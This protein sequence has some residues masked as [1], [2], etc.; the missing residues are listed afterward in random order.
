[1]SRRHTRFSRDWSSDVC[2]SDLFM[3]PL[4]REA[5]RARTEDFCRRALEEG[6]SLA[7]GGKRP[8]GLDKGFFFEPTIFDN[9]TNDSYL[10]Q[11]ERS[12]E[13][14]VGKEGRARWQRYD[15]E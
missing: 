11:R 5:A 9:V 10:G 6:A 1:S 3:G 15:G 7:L 14:R 13:R 2:S 4:I 12:E 8:A